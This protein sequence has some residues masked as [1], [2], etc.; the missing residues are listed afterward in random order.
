MRSKILLVDDEKEAVDML[1]NFLVPRGYHVIT[2]FD[3]DE[4]LRKFDEEQPD[5]VLCDLKMP[6]KDGF[7][8]IKELRATRKWVPIIIISG[9]IEPSNILKGYS[10]KADYFITKPV[11]LAHTLKAT[12]IMLSLVPLRKR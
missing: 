3:A 4:G 10:F 2:A 9:L 7:E 5:I 1:Y 6:K 8:F 12:R 11:D